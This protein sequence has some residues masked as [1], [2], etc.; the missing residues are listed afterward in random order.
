MIEPIIISGRWHIVPNDLQNVSLD[1]VILLSRNKTLKKA[2]K[3]VKNN[4]IKNCIILIQGERFIDA[5][6]QEGKYFDIDICIKSF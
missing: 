2:Y 4:K 1:E 6:D 3:Y 5:H